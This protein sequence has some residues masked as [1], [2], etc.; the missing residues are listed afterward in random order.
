MYNLLIINHKNHDR[1]NTARGEFADQVRNDNTLSGTGTEA[2]TLRQGVS[3]IERGSATLTNH[4]RNI[5]PC[6]TG[7]KIITQG[8]KSPCQGQQ[9][10]TRTPLLRSCRGEKF[11]ALTSKIQL[12]EYYS[13]LHIKNIFFIK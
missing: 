9:Q 8:D 4:S 10:S 12:G 7:T 5:T 11:F 13:P 2:R 3:V 1:D 6:K